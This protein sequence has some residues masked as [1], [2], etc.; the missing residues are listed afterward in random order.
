VAE[1]CAYPAIQK[2]IEVD[3]ALLSHHDYLLC[4]VELSILRIATQHNANTLS[5]YRISPGSTR[6]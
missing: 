5:C 2:S 6:S 1:R 4:D 3:L